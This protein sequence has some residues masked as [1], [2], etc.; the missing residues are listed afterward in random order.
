M[1]TRGHCKNDV[2]AALRHL[3][4]KIPNPEEVSSINP[5]QGVAGVD[6]SLGDCRIRK[7]W[8]FCKA[9]S[10]GRSALRGHNN[11]Q[12]FNTRFSSSILS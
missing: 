1:E 3:R 2:L 5:F 8:A 6:I 12:Q 9:V 10:E 11:P 7:P 4:S